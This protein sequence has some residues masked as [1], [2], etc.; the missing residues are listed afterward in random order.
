MSRTIDYN[1]PSG[2][3]GGKLTNFTYSRS[4]GELI[5]TWSAE[6]A[7]G[8]FKA[9]QTFSVS[10]E[11][12]PVMTNGLIE[13]VWTDP[14][15]IT[16]LTGKDAGVRLMRTTPPA[17][18]LA[19]GGASDVINDLAS[20][21]GMPCSVSGGLTGFNVRS[22]VSG[23]TCAEAI[24]ELAMLSGLVAYIDNNGVLQVRSP[25]LNAPDFNLILDDSGSEL[26][27]DGY[28]SQ[29]TV[30]V[31]RRKKT[32]KEES[33]GGG[34][35]YW[36]GSMP[37]SYTEE[38]WIN[39]SF[40]YTDADKKS[41]S[42][43][44]NIKVYQPIG[45]LKEA[46]TVITMDGVTV[47]T[48]EEH[49]YDIRSQV[50]TRGDQK[51]RLF[52]W[53]ELGYTITKTTE[54]SYEDA[55][56]AI[57]PFWEETVENMVR[58]FDIFNAIW[59]DDEWKNYNPSLNMVAKET[60]ERTTKRNDTASEDS[61]TP[62]EKMPPYTPKFDMKVARDF[63]RMDFG[64]GLL[65]SEIETRY[66]ARQMGKIDGVSKVDANGALKRITILDDSRLLSIPSHTTPVWL[67]IVTYR[68]TYERYK[69]DGTCEVSAKTEWCDEG[70][71]WML[72][73]QAKTGD[74]E[75][76]QTQANYAKFTQKASG[77]SV[78]LDGGNAG[79]V[80]QFME[81]PG[82]VRYT[83]ESD[84]YG[85]SSE[86]WYYNGGYVPSKICPHFESSRR[87]CGI[88]GISA[89]GDFNGET[90]PYRGRGWRN[91]IRAEAALEQAR[92][93]RDRPLLEPPV[94]GVAVVSGGVISAG[95]LEKMNTRPT[96]GYQREFYAE[97]DGDDD[98]IDEGNAKTIAETAARNILKVKR[99]K[100]IRRTVVVPY[101]PTIQP[102]GMIVSVS[103]DWFNMQ[104]TVSYLSQDPN[105][106]VPDFAIPASASGISDGAFGRNSSRQT[107]GMSGTVKSI[108]GGTVNV[109]INAMTYPCTTKLVNIGVGDSVLVSFSSGNSVHGHIVERM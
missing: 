9:G 5:G 15:G 80:W 33:G 100:G 45:A 12:G 75:I 78:S 1:L 22:A 24:L 107:R 53:A 44:Y 99:I 89:I 73:N 76:D 64:K 26:D 27:L 94:I 36:R 61:K 101:D 13:H 95:G 16:H 6:V 82:P 34:G 74:A 14:D 3:G 98:I 102:D 68:T 97:G 4:L 30:S 92:G 29:V 59:I 90:C 87:N 49:S 54:G 35:T 40:S 38:E 2:M 21:C 11:S 85:L 17:R 93:E 91:C 18:L 104:T 46:R 63:K 10:D 47:T 105:D 56:G 20:H 67:P 86:S 62:G 65:I 43:S 7:G 108:E 79:T 50:V 66:E 37:G 23:S 70:S 58:E 84:G 41:V 88:S 31:T 51:F 77:L 52:A 109:E 83:V 81:L 28:A 25:N 69:E 72:T 32:E 96:A 42:G 39:D 60:I 71:R 19:T 48:Q 103:H 55:E 8:A 57:V 106:V